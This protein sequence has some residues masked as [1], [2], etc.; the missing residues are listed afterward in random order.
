SK[1]QIEYLIPAFDPAYAKYS[2]GQLLIEDILKWAFER[3]LDLDFRLGNQ[4]YKETWANS[5]SEA[6]SYQFVISLRGAAFVAAK[7]AYRASKGIVY[8]KKGFTAPTQFAG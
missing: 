4:P 1:L 6:V 2:P 7:K 5:T 3:R 8:R